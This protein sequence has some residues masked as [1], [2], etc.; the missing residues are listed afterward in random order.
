MNSSFGWILNPR[1]IW[2]ILLAFA[3][4]SISPPPARAALIESQLSG[5]Q[6]VSQRGAELETVR[7]ALEHEMVA[8][9]LADYG[10]SQQEVQLKLQT[11]TDAQLHQLA[12]AADTLAEGG[13]ALGV[14]VAVL[15]IILLVIVILKV[16]D[17]EIIIK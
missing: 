7:Q 3:V 12:S 10:F 1:I 13:D 17:N 14:V 11:M 9:R 16:T 5:S 6:V 2:M 8:Q 15:V 4:F